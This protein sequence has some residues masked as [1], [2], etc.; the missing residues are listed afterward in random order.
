MRRAI[1]KASQ[2]NLLPTA[3]SSFKQTNL[4]LFLFYSYDYFAKAS[5]LPPFELYLLTSYI[6]PATS[7]TLRQKTKK[8]SGSLKKIKNP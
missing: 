4:S 1:F 6:L 7:F 8:F 5:S 2:Q 3:E